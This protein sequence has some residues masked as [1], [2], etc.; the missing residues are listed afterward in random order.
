M[1]LALIVN[2]TVVTSYLN[3]LR[4]GHNASFLKPSENLNFVAS[5][6]GW[7]MASKKMFKH[8]NSNYGENI[9]GVGYIAKNGREGTRYVL[10]AIDSWYAEVKKYNYSQPGFNAGHFTALVWNFTREYGV[11]ANYDGIRTVY[12]VME[13]NPPGNVANYYRKNVFPNTVCKRRYI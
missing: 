3:Y 10:S 4:C 8:S 12:I 2:M 1:A 5:N 6:W 9:A 13:F 7:Q 11:S